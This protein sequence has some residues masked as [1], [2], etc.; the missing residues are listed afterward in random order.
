MI[1][2]ANILTRFFDD[3]SNEGALPQPF[4]IFYQE[5]R[6]CYEDALVEQLEYVN[7]S[8]DLPDLDKLL[9]GLNTW[10]IK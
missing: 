1:N 2:K 4:G 9:S 7:D 6:F 10:E 8:N 3:P 5:K